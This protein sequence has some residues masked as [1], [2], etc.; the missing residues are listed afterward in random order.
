MGAPSARAIRERAWPGETAHARL[1][2]GHE[3]RGCP[4][5]PQYP[6]RW[7]PRRRDG[8]WPDPRSPRRSETTSMRASTRPP[9]W[10]SRP[11]SSRAPRGARALRWRTAP[12]WCLR[13]LPSTSPSGPPPGPPTG[14]EHTTAYIETSVDRFALRAGI[15]NFAPVEP[16]TRGL[17]WKASEGAAG[18]PAPASAR[19]H[20]ALR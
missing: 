19:A 14:A 12:A 10:L 20:Q 9:L 17:T 18:S 8:A 4:R 16:T 1:R 5:S 3:A 13:H 15:V 6:R 7:V 11:A 2:E